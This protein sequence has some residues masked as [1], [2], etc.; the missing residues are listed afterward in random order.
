[1]GQYVKALFLH[2]ESFFLNAT[3]KIDDSRKP[4]KHFTGKY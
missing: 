3:A 1:M 2:E 4:P